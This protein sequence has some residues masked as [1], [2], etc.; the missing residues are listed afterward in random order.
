M[1]GVGAYL[2]VGHTAV[3][4]VIAGGVALLLHLKEPMHTFVARIGE[5][6]LKAIMQFVLIALVILPILPD[7]TFG[8]YDVL[9]PHQIWL[10]VVLIV[11]IVWAERRRSAGGS[12]G[13]P[14]LQHCR[15]DQRRTPVRARQVMVPDFRRW[16]SL[17]PPRWPMAECSWR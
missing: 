1:Y 6:D 17:S 11:A 2:V 13:R 8:P 15:H 4:I 10:M 16:S 14:D 9:N 5:T 3:G 7:E 12:A